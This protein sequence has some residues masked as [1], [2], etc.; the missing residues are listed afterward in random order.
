MKYFF[1][2]SELIKKSH[3]LDLQD[4][5]VLT[6]TNGMKNGTFL[7]I[8]SHLPVNNNNTYNLE[9][10]FNWSG[11]SIDL[12]EEFKNE[13]DIHRPN[14]IFIAT[15]ALK[16]DYE[17]LL[18]E[19]FPS[20]DIIDYLQLDIDPSMNTLSALKRIP[21]DKFK[22]RT[23]TY[24]TDFYAEGDVARNESRKILSNLGYELVAEDVLTSYFSGQLLPYEDWWVHPDLIDN[25]IIDFIK[26][27][28]SENSDPRYFLV[29]DFFKINQ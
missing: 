10:Q 20:K 1:N 15:D 8:G 27:R 25:S 21:F 6:A 11:V 12:F 19:Y 18:F 16:I 7:E 29:D 4:I 2:N 24:E 28:S 13:W 22:F 9:I 14:T 17:K 5:F 23:I 3:S 26:S